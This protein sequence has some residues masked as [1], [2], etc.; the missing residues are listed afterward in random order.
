MVA[1]RV[2]ERSHASCE[3][4]VGRCD[5]GRCSCNRGVGFGDHGDRSREQ[6]GRADDRPSESLEGAP[7]RCATVYRSLEAS[8]L[9]CNRPVGWRNGATRSH[10]S[11]V[12]TYN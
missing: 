7:V 8:G 4:A 9:T 2:R 12:A 3:R 6:R 5:G 10:N 11:A 1:G